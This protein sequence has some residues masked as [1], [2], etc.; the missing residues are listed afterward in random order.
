MFS[1]LNPAA[2]TVATLLSALAFVGVSQALAQTVSPTGPESGPVYSTTC[3]AGT[4]EPCSEK[5]DVRCEMEVHFGY[6]PLTQTIEF[7]F[8]K[9]NC[10]VVGYIPIYKDMDKNGLLSGSCNYILPFLGIPE[11]T[12]C[13]D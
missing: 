10:R 7:T 12:N 13:S 5:A 8:K 9:T 6:S 2:T 4:K 3:G 1:R 11:G